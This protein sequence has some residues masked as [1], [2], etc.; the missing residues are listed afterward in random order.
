[1][2]STETSGAIASWT[3]V[4]LAW[5]VSARGALKAPKS[6]SVGQKG[7]RFCIEVNRKLDSKIV[8]SSWTFRITVMFLL[9]QI[10]R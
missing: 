4:A 6:L 9:L 7:H 8:S 3:S 2:N 10:T 5:L 1:M